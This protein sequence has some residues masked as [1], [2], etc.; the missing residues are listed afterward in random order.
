MSVDNVI[1]IP[2]TYVLQEV[3]GKEFVYVIDDVGGESRAKKVYITTSE[4]AEGVVI[5]QEGLTADDMLIGKGAR[6]ISI[7]ELV[8]VQ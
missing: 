1:T 8:K 2:L 6:S 3:D 7:G 4:S 5:V